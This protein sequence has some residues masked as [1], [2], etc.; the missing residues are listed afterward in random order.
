MSDLKPENVVERLKGHP[1]SLA[2]A[3]RVEDFAEP[4]KLAEGLVKQYKDDLK[5]AQLRRFFHTIKNIE[6]RMRGRSEDAPL[7]GEDREDVLRLLPELAY[8]R[9]R[10]LIPGNFYE[11]MKTCLGSEKLKTVKDFRRL[12]AFLTAILAYHKLYS[13]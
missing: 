10:N 4:G 5:A 13:K 3:L 6:R 11:L 12:A 8:A 2:E 7:T 1:G 9:G